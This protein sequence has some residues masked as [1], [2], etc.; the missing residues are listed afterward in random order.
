MA[1][2]RQI[3]RT[4]IRRIADRW[5][6][7]SRLVLV[8]DAAGWSVSHDMEELA[9]IARRIGVRVAGRRF[10]AAAHDQAA[11]FGSQ[12]DLLR[13]D[14]VLPPH[15]LA[16]AYFHGLPGTPGAPEFDECYRALCRMHERIDRVQVTHAQIRELVLSSGIEAT[17]VHTIRIG[18][19]PEAFALRSA[20]ERAEARRRLGIP[21]TALAVGSLQKDGVGWAEGLEPKL[22]KGPDVLV[23]ALA[24]ARSRRPELV[25]VLVGPARG[26]V[27]QELAR[28]G[29]PSVRR[30]VRRHRELRGI[31]AA[32]D[33]V[34]VASRQEGGPKA[35]LE[36]M[37]VGVPVVSTR[38]GQAQELIEDGVN[39][40][41]VDV[42]DAPALGDAIAAAADAPADQVARARTT[43][44]ANAYTAQD[45]RWARFFDGFVAPDG[46]R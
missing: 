35:V 24:H 43:A 20:A 25:A 30:I 28:L 27:E 6:P 37:A 42:E 36:A 32:L 1:G 41:L 7:H 34:V 23:S 9:R 33:A 31:Y 40:R 26:Y 38:V 10:L 46:N 2:P 3:A 12:F 39:G 4:G 45:D 17:K 11:F 16:T 18:V 8:A 5:P 19:D 14:A 29:I 44:V 15:R 21:E 22:V 13:D